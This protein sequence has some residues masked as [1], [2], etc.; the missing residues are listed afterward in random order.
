MPIDMI[1]HAKGWCIADIATFTL[2]LSIRQGFPSSCDK[3][4]EDL[5]TDVLL[6]C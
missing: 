4:F 6:L 3:L 5:K 1:G 2:S